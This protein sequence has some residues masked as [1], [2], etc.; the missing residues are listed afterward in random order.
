[1]PT[2]GYTGLRKHYGSDWT[3]HVV[4]RTVEA[5]HSSPH[6]I[7][8]AVLYPGQNGPRYRT[9]DIDQY[10]EWTIKNEPHEQKSMGSSKH[11]ELLG[12]VE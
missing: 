5:S 3:R 6:P 9:E 8:N 2:L 10:I 1:M 12:A 11:E 4:Q 7:K